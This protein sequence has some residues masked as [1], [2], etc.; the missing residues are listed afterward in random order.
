MDRELLY[1]RQR[2]D[3]DDVPGADYPSEITNGYRTRQV[4]VR[5][6]GEAVRTGLDDFHSIRRST[7]GIQ[8]WPISRS[9]RRS[10]RRLGTV[11]FPHR[12][13]VQLRAVL[14]R[15]EDG[16]PTNQAGEP[17][18]NRWKLRGSSSR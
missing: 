17:F 2:W 5:D 12:R 14:G 8:I 15:D 16:S 6:T 13:L 7:Y 1:L 10:S 9:R 11:P 4:E 3:G 18:Q